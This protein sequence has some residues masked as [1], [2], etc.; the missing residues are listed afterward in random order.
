MMIKMWPWQ[1]RQKFRTWLLGLN[2]ADKKTRKLRESMDETCLSLKPYISWLGDSLAN[3]RTKIRTMRAH[4]QTKKSPNFARSRGL[5]AVQ[6]RTHLSTCERTDS[7]PWTGLSGATATAIASESDS[8]KKK[9]ISK[10]FRAVP[11][12]KSMAPLTTRTNHARSPCNVGNT[13]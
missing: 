2:I 10:A 4:T 6:Q 8:S 13:R 9:Q 11:L 1:T 7:H 5:T 3:R 12:C